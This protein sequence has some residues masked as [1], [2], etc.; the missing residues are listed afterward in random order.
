MTINKNNNVNQSE[1]RKGIL[2][3]S[4]QVVLSLVLIAV[5]LFL[6]VGR[7][8]WIFAWLYIAISLLFVIVNYFILPAEL[9][10]ERGSKKENVEK[11]D[12]IISNLIIIPFV[13][14][15]IVAGLDIR[16]E[17]SYKV[18][19]LIQFI[20]IVI[21]ILGMAIVSWAMV[22][23]PYFSTAVRIQYERVHSV[24]TKGPYKYV[25]HPGYIGM[26]IYNIAT[27]LFLGSLWALI[28][29]VLV[30][31]LYIIR[32]AFED[33]TLKNKLDGY[34][35]YTEKVKYRLLPGIW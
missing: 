9:I 33:S 24:S 31:V 6:S 11:W 10:A 14:L 18:E 19:I 28:P 4:F 13:A 27:P 3:R 21:F 23:N 17:W 12:K 29:A 7:V 2:R 32:T 25:R 30:C 16:F 15:Y 26:I 22:S 20:G 5:L 1:I 8:N 35:E 34:K